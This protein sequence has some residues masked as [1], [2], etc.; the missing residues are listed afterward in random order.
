MQI[1][2]SKSAFFLV[3]KDFNECGYDYDLII[4]KSRLRKLECPH[5]HRQL[6]C[7]GYYLRTIITAKGKKIIRIPRLQCG[8]RECVYKITHHLKTP[9]IIKPIPYFIRKFC[10]YL[11]INILVLALVKAPNPY[12]S[13]V[14]FKYLELGEK[15]YSEPL[16]MYALKVIRR[17]RYKNLKFKAEF[18]LY[19]LMSEDCL[20]VDE[21]YVKNDNLYIKNLIP[22]F[23]QIPL[24]IKYL[25]H[26]AKFALT[27][28]TDFVKAINTQ[29]L[30]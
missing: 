16:S 26:R 20:G 25:L 15:G 30:L 28:P 14:L 27:K 11:L 9:P 23:N 7:S 8:N 22:T 2:L 10:Q 13:K 1:I 12:L 3:K 4:I 5:C 19:F 17:L 29:A 21:V 6:A 24:K 18:L